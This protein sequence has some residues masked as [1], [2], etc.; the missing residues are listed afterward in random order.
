MHFLICILLQLLI[1]VFLIAVVVINA[2]SKK[3]REHLTT[4]T[5]SPVLTNWYV[6]NL[7]YFEAQVMIDKNVPLKIASRTQTSVFA[8]STVETQNSNVDIVQLKASDNTQPTD[9]SNIFFQPLVDQITIEWDYHQRGANFRFEAEAK[10]TPFQPFTCV[11]SFATDPHKEGLVADYRGAI[12]INDANKYNRYYLITKKSSG[13]FAVGVPPPYVAATNNTPNVLQW[14]F[15]D[16]SAKK[17][18]SPIQ[19]LNPRKTQ[20][21]NMQTGQTLDE[22]TAIL[23]F[24]GLTVLGINGLQYKLPTTVYP[25]QSM[26]D[27]EL[28]DAATEASEI[29]AE[30]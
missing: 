25:E 26:G 16:Q 28:V 22:I 5:P 2:L 23:G 12:T 17:N 19:Y 18:S 1:I 8:A 10:F 14:E 4:D 13:K 3:T 21:F 20:K 7:N 27:V 29:A 15:W 11:L 9:V 30:I 6:V 24:V